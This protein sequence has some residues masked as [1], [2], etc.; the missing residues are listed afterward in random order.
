MNAGSTVLDLP[1]ASPHLAHDPIL[2][3]VKEDLRNAYGERLV[4]IVLYGSRARGDNRPDSD[5]DILALV[6]N[7]RGKQDDLRVRHLGAEI[8]LNTG[9]L[10][11]LTVL[12]ENG[13]AR[14]TGFMF[15]VRREG[16]ML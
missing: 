13:L 11:N 14:R 10:I 15:N 5:V 12:P 9:A 3:Q 1:S 16:L 7:Y 2:R 6:K 4:G 8:L